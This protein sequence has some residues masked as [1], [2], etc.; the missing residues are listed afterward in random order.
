MQQLAL[1]LVQL[2]WGLDP[3]F[4]EQVALAVTVQDGHA[5]AAD[6]HR[7]ARLRAFGNL[8]R[9]FA[10]QRRHLNLSAQRGLGK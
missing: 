2:V 7:R 8:Q 5:F 9:V 3:H 4:D 1:A 10:F 6:S